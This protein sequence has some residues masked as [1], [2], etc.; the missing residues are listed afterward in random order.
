MTPLSDRD[1]E[2]VNAWADNELAEPEATQFAKR[3]QREP[4]LKEALASV[5]QVSVSLSMLRPEPGHA[6]PSANA[7]RRPWLW[8]AGA[9]LA[10][11]VAGIAILL[12]LDA[13]PSATAVHRGYVAQTYQP[14]AG[15][16]L[17]L[18]AGSVVDGFP[19]LGDANLYLVATDVQKGRASAHFVGLN[20]CRLT[21]L[22]GDFAPPEVSPDVQVHQWL[23]ENSRYQVIATGMDAGKFAAIAAYL[24][25]AT[26]SRLE[27]TTVL[28]LRQAVQSATTCRRALS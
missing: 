23:A 18:A 11:A 21:V 7:N 13:T 15:S 9:G 17:R 27:D 16:D 4:E 25:Q 1:W 12:M 2:L 10:A 5:R 19:L 8:A 22:R 14:Q 6:T 24:E 3:L 20:G 28:A 26:Q